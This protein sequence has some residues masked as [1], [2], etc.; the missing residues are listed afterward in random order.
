MFIEPCG[1][2]LNFFKHHSF[3]HPI[4]HL[5]IF[6]SPSFNHISERIA[7]IRPRFLLM[8]RIRAEAEPAEAVMALRASHVHAAL[9]LLNRIAALRARLRIQLDPRL[10]VIIVP[11]YPRVPLAQVEAVDRPVRGLEAFEAEVSA[12]A[13]ENVGLA[14]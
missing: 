4:S 12:A 14:H 13:A 2:V 1:V 9:I 6:R 8:V 3:L 5:L 7:Q 10:R 11:L